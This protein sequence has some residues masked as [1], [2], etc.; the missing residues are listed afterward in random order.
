MTGSAVTNS[1]GF[2]RPDPRGLLE[3]RDMPPSDSLIDLSAALAVRM[4]MSIKGIWHLRCWHRDRLA[5][6]YANKDANK[7]AGC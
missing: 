7:F 1:Y 6:A 3:P 4:A 5:F 2:R